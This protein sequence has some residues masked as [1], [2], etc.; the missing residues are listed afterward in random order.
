MNLL[1]PCRSLYTI[2]DGTTCNDG[3]FCTKQD[4][5]EAGTCV[6]V[7]RCP[8]NTYCFRYICRERLKKCVKIPTGKL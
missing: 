3:K 4:R 1:L 5:C 2:A 6:G 7:R 8:K